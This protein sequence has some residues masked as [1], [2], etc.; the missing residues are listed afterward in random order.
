MRLLGRWNWWMPV[1]LTRVVA[2]RLPASEA[3]AEASVEAAR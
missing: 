2:D 3:E 1:W